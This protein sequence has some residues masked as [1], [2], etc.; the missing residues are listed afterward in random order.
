MATVSSPA[1]SEP[2]PADPD[3]SLW[4]N[5]ESTGFEIIE[6]ASDGNCFYDAFFRAVIGSPDELRGRVLN[7]LS[8]YIPADEPQRARFRNLTRPG[9]T[10]LSSL[11]R[12][13][14]LNQSAVS[15]GVPPA[16]AKNESFKV[17]QRLFVIATR[18][19]YA[20]KITQQDFRKIYDNFSSNFN[21]GF[22]NLRIEEDFPY[23][24]P[25]DQEA[26]KRIFLKGGLF[27]RSMV[28]EG[29][30][31]NAY[32][33][34]V[35]SM[36]AKT[37]AT[38]ETI[39]VVQQALGVVFVLLNVVKGPGGVVNSAN[40]AGEYSLNDSTN[41][42]TL[43][44]SGNH[45]ETLGYGVKRAQPYSYTAGYASF[46]TVNA[47][48]QKPF[49]NQYPQVGVCP[50]EYAIYK[51]SVELLDYLCILYRKLFTKGEFSSTEFIVVNDETG[52]Q[53]ISAFPAAP[54]FATKTEVIGPAGDRVERIVVIYSGSDART[55]RAVQEQLGPS[56]VSMRQGDDPAF[57]LTDALDADNFQDKKD[58]F[59]ELLTSLENAIAELEG[60]SN[61]SWDVYAGTFERRFGSS[62]SR[63]KRFGS[64]DCVERHKTAD[65]IPAVTD[66]ANSPSFD[67]YR[68]KLE[69][70]AE[71]ATESTQP[72]EAA[73]S[74]AEARTRQ[75]LER[76][77]RA[78]AAAQAKRLAKTKE[79][80]A[81]RAQ[82][83]AE[84][85]E[86]E[87]KKAS[88]KAKAEAQR[89]VATAES[90][91]A[92]Q[93]ETAE[94]LNDRWNA[95]V[96]RTAETWSDVETQF[97]KLKAQDQDT[98]L[99]VLEEGL[100]GGKITEKGVSE[101]VLKELRAFAQTNQALMNGLR[102]LVSLISGL[103][104]I[105]PDL[106]NLRSR[107]DK[108][109]SE[110]VEVAPDAYQKYVAYVASLKDTNPVFH[111]I[112]ARI[113]DKDID[114]KEKAIDYVKATFSSAEFTPFPRGLVIP[115]IGELEKEIVAASMRNNRIYKLIIEISPNPYAAVYQG[116]LSRVDGKTKQ[117]YEVVNRNNR[118]TH[119][120]IDP[121]INPVNGRLVL[122]AASSPATEIKGGAA[123]RKRRAVRTKKPKRKSSSAGVS[124]SGTRRRGRFA[125]SRSSRDK[126]AAP[127][128]AAQRRRRTRRAQ[129]PRRKSQRERS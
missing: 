64:A 40:F 34:L 101:K 59:T 82:K 115:S 68:Q 120:I 30:A 119:G 51:E 29:T 112:L 70:R 22:K 117:T 86:K 99:N 37:W 11:M 105:V 53:A 121:Y 75:R 39:A 92:S 97:A 106:I 15:I 60:E 14:L 42:F 46:A 1:P 52:K 47:A 102:G 89:K 87:A 66:V 103:L 93:L 31:F 77:E 45:Y 61:R 109:S 58:K 90:L 56:L 63:A 114:T 104:K 94:R 88:D 107:V 122:A 2:V 69:V 124:K 74:D 38:N 26:L 96:A 111:A 100:G 48:L 128:L 129:K 54:A 78:R 3:H 91:A 44:F 9:S 23:Y 73:I 17:F 7:E 127:G 62:P 55:L 6:T 123:K 13:A 12:P 8:E 19:L 79:A 84:R 27:R 110:T 83:A 98:Q 41:L 20:D 16:E 35:A 113:G 18:N 10:V 28:D 126:K 72:P 80:E 4:T 57:S 125:H 108:S 32:K 65:Q 33:E 116:T 43:V 21:R 95:G 24:S 67:D 25:N 36:D 71:E 50:R 118:T 49:C 5:L 76:N 81:R 85:A